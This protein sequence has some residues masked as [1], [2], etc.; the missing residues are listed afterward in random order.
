MS[1]PAFHEVVLVAIEIPSLAYTHT[2]SL[3]ESELPSRNAWRVVP[4]V[5]PLR[6]VGALPSG[7]RTRD[8]DDDDNEDEVR[9]HTN[10]AV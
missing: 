3:N 1:P 4:P 7:V 6:L 10:V 8:N 5:V 9:R 2:L